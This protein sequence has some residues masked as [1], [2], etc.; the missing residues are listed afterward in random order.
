MSYWLPSCQMQAEILIPPTVKQ[1]IPAQPTLA[2]TQG[3][4]TNE[5]QSEL[6]TL[7]ALP[8]LPQQEGSQGNMCKKAPPL[9]LRPPNFSWFWCCAEGLLGYYTHWTTSNWQQI[10]RD[11]FPLQPQYL[12]YQVQAISYRSTRLGELF[13]AVKRGCARVGSLQHFF[14]KASI[15]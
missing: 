8:L 2:F 12:Y 4:Q 5:I 1:L 6:D 10:F 11:H 7:T 13:K 14:L 15:L 3:R 9:L